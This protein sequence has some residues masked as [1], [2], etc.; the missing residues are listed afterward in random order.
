MPMDQLKNLRKRFVKFKEKPM[1][2]SIKKS[3]SVILI[4][5][6]IFSSFSGC[7]DNSM[8]HIHFFKQKTDETKHFKECEC[9]KIIDSEEHTFDWIIDSE[10]SYNEPGLKHRECSACAY[11]EENTIIERLI[12]TDGF[13][14][15]LT[16]DLPN[17]KSFNSK[18]KLVE[19]YEEQKNKINYSFLCID[20]SSEPENGIYTTLSSLNHYRFHYGEETEKNYTNPYIVVS[21][22]I[23]SNEWGPTLDAEV[24]GVESV[25]FLM[26]FYGIDSAVDS[27]QLEFYENNDPESTL[28]FVV[29]IMSGDVYVGIVFY[30]TDV[31]IN[32]EWIADYLLRNLFVLN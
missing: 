27:Y 21:Y 5:L 11:K 13:N 32:R 14:N 12:H 10:P 30:S 29:Q 8:F 22:G 19:F 4:L 26:Y 18:E 7:A 16:I 20:V 6:I 1:R 15:G 23:Y 2:K 9:G 31:Y 28:N 25:G 17:Q 3:A 24:D